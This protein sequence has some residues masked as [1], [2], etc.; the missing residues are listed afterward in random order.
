[1]LKQLTSKIPS[2]KTSG[3][4]KQ[5]LNAY[6]LNKS[7][8]RCFISNKIFANNSQ[9]VCLYKNQS[10]SIFT[11]YK[12]DKNSKKKVEWYETDYPLVFENGKYPIL[13][14]NNS[15]RYLASRLKNYI[16]LPVMILTGYKCVKS[17]V[18]F[19]PVRSILWGA[20]F[21]MALR[22]FRGINHNKY[23]FVYQVNLL[24]D[25]KSI[26]LMGESGPKVADIADIRKLTTE[27]SIYLSQVFPDAYV[28]YI[29]VVVDDN[30]YLIF[31]NSKVN[32]PDLLKATFQNK[33]IKVKQDNIINKDEAID[34]DSK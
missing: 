21:L 3:I 15:D 33:Y 4:A 19:R 17:I 13:V 22:V 28:V 25:G 16:I 30:F 5:T 18:L 12:K 8:Q 10:N 32:D 31:K 27:E 20:G 6:N 7:I 23:Y 29:P 26:E 2:L 9:E 34:I 14:A 11:S 24:E 1:M